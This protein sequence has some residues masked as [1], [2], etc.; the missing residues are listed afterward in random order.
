MTTPADQAM[1]LLL[2]PV[3]HA[4]NNLSMVLTANLESAVPRMPEGER[5][6]KL[7][8]RAWD[9]AQDYD[10]L[11]RGYL[12]LGREESVRSGRADRVIGDLLPLLV[13]ASGG[14]LALEGEDGTAVEYRSPALE[15]ALVLAM[16]GASGLPAGPR[17]PLRLARGRVELGWA[18][19][20]AARTA[21]EAAGARVEAASVVLPQSGGAVSARAAS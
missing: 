12:A 10:R 18:V 19:P 21:L 6:T 16:S 9:A 17:P 1:A 8:T 2:R 15:S 3:R 4:V 14:P 7:V 5:V 13:L 20:E 11:A